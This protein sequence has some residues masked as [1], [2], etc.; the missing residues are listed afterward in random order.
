MNDSTRF[1]STPIV[2]IELHTEGSDT[3]EQLAEV[4]C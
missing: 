3:P 2:F 4:P 1:V